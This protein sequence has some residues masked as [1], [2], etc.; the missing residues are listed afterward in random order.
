MIPQDFFSD[1][2]RELGSTYFI[3]SSELKETAQAYNI[4]PGITG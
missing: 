3:E 2:F 4:Q 1:Q